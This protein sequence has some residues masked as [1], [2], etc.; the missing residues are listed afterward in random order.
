MSRRNTSHIAI[1]HDGC[2]F[3]GFTFGRDSIVA[4]LYDKTAEICPLGQ[5]RMRAVWGDRLDPSIPVWRLEFQLR[6]EV[7]AECML[8]APEEILERRQDLW[9]Y[10][11]QWLSLRSVRR[12]QRRARWP[13][14]GVRV[15]L[16]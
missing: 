3:T 7:L 10:A 15:Q 11:M 1:H 6:R 9:S 16:L 8:S 5:R 4:R 13:V 14:A 2:R 12:G